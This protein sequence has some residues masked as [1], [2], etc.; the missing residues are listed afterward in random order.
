MLNLLKCPS[1]ALHVLHCLRKTLSFIFSCLTLLLRCF[2]QIRVPL[3]LLGHSIYINPFVPNAP[4]LYPLKI[5]ENRK[6]FWYFQGVEEGCIWSKRVNILH[7]T[8]A[9]CSNLASRL[10]VYCV[11]QQIELILLRLYKSKSLLINTWKN[12]VFAMT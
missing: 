1:S 11:D 2:C 6:V 12:W 9:P 4:F 7:L 3:I 8:I 5:S 10:V